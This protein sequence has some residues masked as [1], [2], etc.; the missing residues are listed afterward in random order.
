MIG[1]ACA[2]AEVAAATC[3]AVGANFGRLHRHRR[4]LQARCS[5]PP[6][7]APPAPRRA[8][9]QAHVALEP[10]RRERFQLA[11]DRINLGAG[12]RVERPGQLRAPR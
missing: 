5:P 6:A 8:T 9:K 4:G 11:F 10:G 1:R 7:T 12:S 2:R 3:A